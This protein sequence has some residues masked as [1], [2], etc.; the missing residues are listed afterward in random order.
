VSEE[1]TALALLAEDA[2]SWDAE[3]VIRPPGGE[4]LHQRG[5]AEMRLIGGGRWLVLDFR[6]D[7][8]FDGHGVYGWDP[9][10][11]TFQSIWVDNETT[12]LTVGSGSW[13]A[14]ARAFT[15][16]RE[17]EIRG[18]PFRWREVTERPE[19]DTRVFRSFVPGPDGTEHEL[20]TVTYRRRPS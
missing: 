13:D 16:E 9:A 19:A 12:W 7:S 4:E 15:Y 17:A 10:R 3:V 2:G 1:Q 18:A 20:L 6:N 11:G 8:G 14:V 5:E